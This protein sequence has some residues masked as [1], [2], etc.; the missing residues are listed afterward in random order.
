MSKKQPTPKPT[1]AKPETTAPAAKPEA[2][3]KP[4]VV[5]PVVTAD[6]LAALRAAASIDAA[7]K[8]LQ[9][10]ARRANPTYQLVETCPN[11]LPRAR[12][13]CVRVYAA[14]ARRTG[15]FTAKDIATEL[16]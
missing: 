10:E 9:P 12:G 4:E 8:V 11:P 6:L 3:A 2:K 16:P 5:A 13:A 1:T 14:I 15:T 7:V